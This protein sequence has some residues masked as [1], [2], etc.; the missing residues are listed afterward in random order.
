MVAFME[1]DERSSKTESRRSVLEARVYWTTAAAEAMR[2]VYRNEGA[3]S[4]MK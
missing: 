1:L 4:S 3:I 2:W